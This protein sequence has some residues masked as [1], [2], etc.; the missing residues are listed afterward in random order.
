M[1]AEMTT[2][3]AIHDIV[4]R[5]TDVQART[6]L[7]LLKA[8]T[9]ESNDA[10]TIDKSNVDTST[11]QLPPTPLKHDSMDD[12]IGIAQSNPPTDIENFK[13]EYIAEAIESHWK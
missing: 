6:L 3:Q 8:F 13:D 1:R 9:H 7:A 10:K 5:L 2:K 4:D 12:I 11:D